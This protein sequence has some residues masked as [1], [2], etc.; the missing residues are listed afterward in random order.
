MKEIEVF[1][2]SVYRNV[3]G[4]KEEVQELKS[5]MRSHLMEAVHD[6]K[7]HGK[8]EEEAIRIAIEN[9]GDKKQI[10][11]G[12]S[13]FFN[14][15]KQFTLSVLVISLISF[16]IGTFFLTTTILGIKEFRE[17]KGII[18]NDVFNVLGNSSEI[19]SKQEGQILDIY[20][21]HHEHLNKLAVFKVNSNDLKEWLKENK[22]VKEGPKTY[23]PIEYKNS[24]L[25]IGN[26]GIV[27]NKEEIVASDYDL[28]T[29]VMA[30]NDWIVQYEYSANYR[31]VIEE[32]NL[33]ALNSAEYIMNVFQLPILFFVVSVV[34]G[35]V[36]LFLKKNNRHFKNVIG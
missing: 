15:Q 23:H 30:K 36:W 29:V 25:V 32:N 5:E 16:I 17:E 21:E 35:V 22:F 33:L 28:G 10:V 4:N 13:E 7:N 31:T 26:E 19:S 24:I 9:F 11:K 14:V 3:D 12:L 34:L 20:R 27:P 1:V 18:M 2:D 8:T 6:L